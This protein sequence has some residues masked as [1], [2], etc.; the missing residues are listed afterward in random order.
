[1]RHSFRVRVLGLQCCEGY[2][3]TG[4]FVRDSACEWP[5]VDQLVAVSSALGITGKSEEPSKRGNSTE[6]PL[7][8]VRH[9]ALYYGQIMRRHRC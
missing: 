9:T 4:S 3:P 6:A 1:V 2:E 5:I 8:A 7:R